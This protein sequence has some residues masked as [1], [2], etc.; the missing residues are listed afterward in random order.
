MYVF[1]GGCFYYVYLFIGICG[2]GKMMLL[3]IFVKV[4]NCEIG[5]MLQLCGVCCVCCEIDEGCFVDYVEMDVVSNCGVDEMV[6][7]FECVVY[8]F[9]DVCFKVYM[10]DEVYMLMN[11]V[12][13]VM[14]KMLEEL[15]LYVKFIFVMIDL[16]KIFVIVLLCCLQFNL[17]QMLVGYIVLYFEWIFGEE[18]IMFE[19]Q[20]LCLFVWVVQGSMC[21]VLLL[22][23][24]VIV[25]LVNEVIE[26]V[27]LGMFGVFDQIYM[28]YLFDVFVVGNGLEIFVIVDEMLLCSLLFLIVLQDFVSLL[29]W[30]VWVQFVLGLVFDE[31]LEVV[32]LCWFV[33]MLSFEQVQLFY[34]IVMVG[35]VEFGLVLDEYVG[36]MMMLLWMFVFELVVGVGS[37]LGGQLFVLLCVVLVLCVV[38]V[39][40]VVVVKLVLVMF[41]GGVV[42]L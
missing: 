12:F 19:L 29:Y 32:D 28:V 7:L 4:F 39:L 31:W 42:C 23:D 25:Y 41:V 17:K 8:V 20:V 35:C 5:V 10:I 18:W 30:I 15:L 36:F 40:I 1:D 27:V 11:Y 13:N 34:Q 16:Q 26:L 21:D 2:V 37:V 9:V 24:Q 14:L 3:W 22:I 33:E 6:V 38:V